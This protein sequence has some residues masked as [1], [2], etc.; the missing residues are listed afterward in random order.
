MTFRSAPLALALG[1]AMTLSLGAL[2]RAEAF[3]F[4]TDFSTNPS[5]TGDNRWRGDIWLNSVSYGSQTFNQFSL[6]NQVNIVQND[7]W[8]GGNSGAASADRGRF[9]TVGTSEER[10]TTGGAVTALGNLNLSSIIDGE[11]RGSF[12]LDLMFNRAARDVLVWERG[13]NSALDVQALDA[14][15]N[16]VG[17]LITITQGMWKSAG[18]NLGTLEIGDGIQAV[19]S[20]GLSA[21]DF[22]LTGNIYGV[23]V[24]ARGDAFYNGP[25]FKVVGTAAEAVP[26]PAAL[27]GLGALALVGAASRRRQGNRADA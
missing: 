5:L 19:G 13:M 15:G 27:F 12:T 24:G 4:T 20:W 22:G 14:N 25:D 17:N 26:E 2:H 10:L 3:S 21:A 8:T 9:S 1:T 23:R 11:D 6:V 16:L 18:F 7:L